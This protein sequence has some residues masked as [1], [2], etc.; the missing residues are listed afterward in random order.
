MGMSIYP[1]LRRIHL[2]TGLILLVFVLMY[3]VTGYVMIHAKWFGGRE[4]KTTKYT[5][6][7]DI[8]GT[9]ADDVLVRRLQ[10]ELGFKGQP[11]DPEHR[12]GGSIRLS[13]TRPGTA[14][15]LVIVPGTNLVTVTRK[16]FGFAG[17]ANGMHRLRGYNGGWRYCAWSL[18]YD[19]ASL[20]LIVFAL[21]GILLWYAST[22]RRLTGWLCLAAGCGF[23][24]ST[25]LYLML[26][27]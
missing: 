4:A 27:K 2:F 25:V 9:M 17:V 11:S 5:E 12:K 18:L 16:D 26:S 6:K 10:T 20:A 1:S 15:Q 7:L 22:S 3:F 14:F 24:A 8:N 19:L 13:F 21:T 23:T